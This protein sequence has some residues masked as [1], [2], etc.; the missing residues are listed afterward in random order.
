MIFASGRWFFQV[1]VHLCLSMQGVLS[2]VFQPFYRNL[3]VPALYALIMYNHTFASL[4]IISY[5]ARTR[6]SQRAGLSYYH[7][8]PLVFPHAPDELQHN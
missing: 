5:Y 1:P 2:Y 8:L 6:N 3:T 7:D 4:R